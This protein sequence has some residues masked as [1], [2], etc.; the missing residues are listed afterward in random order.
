MALVAPEVFVLCGAASWV[1]L[2][3]VVRLV[4][5]RDLAA[6]GVWSLVWLSLGVGISVGS[7]G[8]MVF[9]VPSLVLVLVEACV[10][11]AVWPVL[12]LYRA[13][14][15]V[16]LPLVAVISLAA[17]WVGI[18]LSGDVALDLARSVLLLA[19]LLDRL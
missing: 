10:V 13:P 19:I 2:P 17:V 12:A 1:H 4:L 18:V 5:R 8:V 7:L 16:C 14:L 9:V 15:V 11:L 6:V 3:L